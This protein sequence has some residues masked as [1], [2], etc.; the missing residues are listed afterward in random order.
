MC[1]L[2][3]SLGFAPDRKR[4]DIVAHRGPDGS[5]WAEFD[6][7]SGP[8]ALGHRRLAIIDVSDAGL[9]PMADPS[10]R[11]HL[12]F[13]GEIY[14]YL[15]LRE[16]LRAKGHVFV[17]DSDSE[18]LIA[19][20]AEWGEECL[21]RFLGMFAFLLWDRR[22][23]RL[24]AARDRFGIKPLYVV[25]NRH[26]VA[27]GSEIKQLLGL[28]GLSGSMN[29]PRVRD[30]LSSGVTNH[31]PET[32]FDGV[33]QVQPGCCASIE[34][35]RQF[36][37]SVA[38]RRWYAIP[39]SSGLDLSEADA[40][41]RFHELFTDSIRMHLRSDVP[42]GS[43]LSGGLDSSSIVCVMS[44]MLAREGNGA[45][46]NTV[47]ACYA[48][49]S[50]DEKPFMET[51]VA[52]TNALPH[53]IFP[54]PDDVFARASDITW[55][56]DEPFGSTSIFAQW[57]VFEEAK[58]VGIKVMLDGQGADEQLA[59]YHSGYMY[60]MSNLIRQRQYGTLLR[61]MAE[62][63][64]YHGVSFTSQISRYM[65]P[66]LPPQ[67][68]AFLIRQRQ[69]LVFHDW[70]NSDVF[71]TLGPARSVLEIASETNGLPKITDIASLCLVLT[72][73]SNLPM[74]LH[75]EDR[76]SMAHSVEARVPFLDHRLVEFN[77]ALGNS[78][79]IVRGDTKRVLRTAM[80]GIL[81]ESVRQRRDKLGFA[82]PEQTWLRGP[83]KG[84]ITEGI[85]TTLK[86]YPG[87]LDEKGTRALASDMLEGRREVD[88][89][90]WRIANLGMW[91]ERFN[92]SL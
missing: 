9:Q 50:V 81:P 41:E 74:L 29:L 58:R 72:M 16:E 17:S 64:Q 22:D 65:A 46:V 59:G 88:F 63:S 43:C 78:H 60:Y 35:G 6:S 4:I 85:E 31:T 49:K 67:M 56:Q 13:N 61:T 18:V 48:E 32:L 25:A 11:Y 19:S 52:Q 5:G 24:F 55:H 38:P 27:F 87:L 2:Y 42:I 86:R 1:G 75:W 28:P 84:L 57:C 12:V 54:K 26:G 69:S 66:L 39:A 77:L 53:Y 68:R 33:L 40:A 3:G 80:K 51:V 30:F 89:S 45:R 21:H 82:T 90:L 14:N 20:Y 36:T 23:Q 79:K 83:L 44:D 73:A 7:R 91:G 76:N 92:I 70:T 71:R 62:R 15:E 47:S 10:G 37:G 8:I 34:A